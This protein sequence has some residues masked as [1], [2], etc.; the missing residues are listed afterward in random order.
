MRYRIAGIAIPIALGMAFTVFTACQKAPP[1]AVVVS[2]IPDRFASAEQIE[3]N[4]RGRSFILGDNANVAL[5]R[6]VDSLK[7][8]WL[9]LQFWFGINLM[10]PGAL[11][12]KEGEY[13]VISEA[14]LI[15]PLD[16]PGEWMIE[17]G[18]SL[19]KN[20]TV[21]QTT[22]THYLGTGK[23]LPTVVQFMGMR[24]FKTEDGKTVQMP[25]L[26]E[27][28]LPMKWTL[29]GGGIPASYARY[30]TG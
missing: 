1:P 19:I 7:D 8:A 16:A 14:H 15:K 9:K 10:V 12:P 5:A 25:I 29:G 6:P 24:E 20:E 28:S 22:R 26:R 4:F 27:V 13:Y 18:S 21:L 30:R 17:A 23:I 3:E 11:Q 2:G